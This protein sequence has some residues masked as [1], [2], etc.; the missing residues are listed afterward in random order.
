[1]IND[2]S[3]EENWD[4][5]GL[6]LPFDVN[7]IDVKNGTGP[8]EIIGSPT[9]V[10]N[11]PNALYDGFISFNGT[12]DRIRYSDG[13]NTTLGNADFT[14]EF[15][16]YPKV[17]GSGPGADG[18]SR[19]IFAN[20]TTFNTGSTNKTIALVLNGPE[21]ILRIG[22]FAIGSSIEIGTYI[23]TH[24]AICKAG[25]DVRF[26]VDGSLIYT[27]TSVV[28]DFTS[29]N[30]ILGAT[31]IG[32]IWSYYNGNIDDFRLTTGYA[33]YTEEFSPPHQAYNIGNTEYEQL[34]FFPMVQL[35]AQHGIADKS[36]N[37]RPLKPTNP[38]T[39]TI[40]KQFIDGSP[41]FYFHDSCIITSTS[42]DYKLSLN[43]F[44]I[45]AWIYSDHTNAE[46]TICASYGYPMRG[47]FWF[48]TYNNGIYVNSGTSDGNIDNLSY[49]GLVN[50]VNYV[51][52]IPVNKWCHVAWTRSNDTNRLF[53][54][55]KLAKTFTNKTNWTSNILSIGK[56]ALAAKRMNIAG[57][58]RWWEPVYVEQYPFTGFLNDFKVTNLLCKYTTDFDPYEPYSSNR[59]VDLSLFDEGSVLAK[60]FDVKMLSKIYTVTETNSNIFQFN[61]SSGFVLRK[62]ASDIPGTWITSAV[63]NSQGD[64]IITLSDS[65]IHNVGNISSP[66]VNTP[67][68]AIGTGLLT[69]KTADTL[70]FTLPT[71]SGD[72][73]IN[74]T[75]NSLIITTNKV[76]ETSLNTSNAFVVGEVTLIGG[77]APAT[78]A[79]TWQKR[80]VN[81]VIHPHTNM[82][83][84]NGSLILP[85]GKYY[86]S[87]C[88]SA[89][90][91]GF[92]ALRLF[93]TNNN[94]VLVSANNGLS[95]TGAS[96]TIDLVG[97]FEL[98]ASTTIN[99]EMFTTITANF[100]ATVSNLQMYVF[101]LSFFRA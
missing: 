40:D 4:N 100:S 93:D 72:T 77:T 62:P 32:G 86:V 66:P 12:A 24:V 101:Y 42:N 19:G 45:E 41:S 26:F 25:S 76:F 80:L 43:D 70:T 2:P 81:T 63:I 20:N 98:I 50:T 47:N 69:S 10:K 60:N 83:S 95:T 71:G 14:I 28:H 55:G 74:D 16:I 15:W 17:I 91:S 31:N 48:G 51:G 68:T 27:Y 97:E 54:D 92:T 89:Y 21:L 36:F 94:A 11:H 82:K 84:I 18:A 96:T 56:S 99:V 23:W 44:T 1:M 88:A 5:V 78:V 59:P 85:A 29:S 61:D 30:L 67:I 75:T 38:P 9:V 6:L 7:L 90:S 33:R 34:N 37:N 73:V 58:T 49:T 8:A 39:V 87:G 35:L 57:A 13:L 3:V 53:I 79:N 52:S 65:T 46:R 64:C 22:G